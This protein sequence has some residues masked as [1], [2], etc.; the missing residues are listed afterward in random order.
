[1]NS[2]DLVVTIA[3]GSMLST[4]LIDSKISLAEGL[5]GIALLVLLQFIITWLSVRC[6]VVVKIVK[7]QPALLF[8]E[9]GFLREAMKSMRVLY[10][11]RRRFDS[12]MNLRTTA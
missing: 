11:R 9:S 10:R 4:I 1:M 5:A 2:F 8:R 7:T 6:V 12:T 3:F